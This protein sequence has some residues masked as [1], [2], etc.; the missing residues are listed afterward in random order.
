MDREKGTHLA[1][2]SSICVRVE[3]ENDNKMKVELR[4]SN[5][6]IFMFLLLSQQLPVSLMAS[7]LQR[8]GYSALL[9]TC[10]H[11]RHVHLIT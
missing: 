2:C 5:D 7:A 6:V 1:P 4:V 11:V 9:G 10:A 3:R 8:L